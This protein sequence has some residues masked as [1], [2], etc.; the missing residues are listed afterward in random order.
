MRYGSPSIRSV[1]PEMIRAGITNLL[2]VPMYPQYSATST[3][4]ALD[5]LFQALQKERYIPRVRIISAYY[6][7][8]AYLSAVTTQMEEALAKLSWRPDHFILTYHARDAA[9]WLREGAV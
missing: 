3:A 7:H 4:S 1:L 5:A 9:R 8:P 2:A 6:D